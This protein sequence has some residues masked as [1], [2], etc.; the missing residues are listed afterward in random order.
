MNHDPYPCESLDPFLTVCQKHDGH[1]SMF[2]DTYTKN[3]GL[4]SSGRLPAPLGLYGRQGLT[5]RERTVLSGS[6]KLFAVSTA[7][8]GVQSYRCSG[9]PPVE[10]TVPAP[11][12]KILI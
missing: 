7:P 11:G 8:C 12:S 1:H 4:D 5:L 2:R 10:K 9:S 6:I 3:N